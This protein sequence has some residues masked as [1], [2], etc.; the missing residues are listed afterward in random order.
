MA[1]IAENMMIVRPKV[2]EI[3]I[4]KIENKLITTVFCY[5]KTMPDTIIPKSRTMLYAKTEKKF[6]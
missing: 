1:T 4:P 5:K 3:T 6:K 2:T